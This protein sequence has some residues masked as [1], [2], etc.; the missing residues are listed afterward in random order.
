[1]LLERGLQKVEDI[2]NVV[3]FGSKSGVCFNSLNTLIEM[4]SPP[5]TESR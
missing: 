4:D 2:E 3:L 5:R 1:M